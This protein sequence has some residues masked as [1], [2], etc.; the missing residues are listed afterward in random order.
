MFVID[1]TMPG[2]IVAKVALLRSDVAF[3]KLLAKCYGGS[4][5]DGLLRG[6]NILIQHT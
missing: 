1:R 2:F 4:A 3:I 6:H 5:V